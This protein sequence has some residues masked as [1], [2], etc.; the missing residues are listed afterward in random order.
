[1]SPTRGR[2]PT[3]LVIGAMKA[4]TTSLYHYLRD[5]PQIFMPPTKEI[6]FFDERHNWHRG[7][8]WYR[9][10]FADAGDAPAVGEASTSYT[11]YPV[12]DGVPEKIASVL[13]SPRL[14]YVL[15]DPIERLRSHYLY[16]LTRGTEWRSIEE[17]VASEP[18]YVDFGRYAMQL[19]R[20]LPHLGLDA[21]LLVDS[22]DLRAERQTTLSRVYAFLG[23]DERSIPRSADREFFRAEDRRLRPRYVLALR[24]SARV[25][26]LA[27][28]LPG[29]VKA[30]TRRLPTSVPD[31]D[32]GTIAP[33]LR[34]RLIDAFADD[35]VTLRTYLG[36]RFDGW[37]IA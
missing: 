18:A 2:L 26:A 36:P 9:T 12:V 31:L 35:I 15:R 25:R 17:A 16:N 7:V 37:G 28:R 1:M 33:S 29:S 11:K 24:R 21:M 14:I 20:Y 34:E 8:D 19:E 5:H 6:M 10:R 4:G 22:R 30:A 13:G 3:F 27:S 32:R 23:V